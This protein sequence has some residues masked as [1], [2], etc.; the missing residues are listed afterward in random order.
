MTR[1]SHVIDR[2]EVVFD[3][4]RLV[5]NAGLLLVATLT[6]QLGL[7]ALINATVKLTGRVGGSRPGRKVLTLVNSMIAGGTH[8]DHADVLRS[9]ST[10]AVLSHRVMA[11]STLGTFLRAFTFGHVRQLEAVV[12]QALTR[13]WAAGAGPKVA[14][15]VID[16]D[17]TICEVDGKAKQ[18]AGYGYTKKLGYHPLL[19]TR[20]DTGEVLHARMRKGQANTQRGARRFIDEVVAR[21]RRAGATGQL[22][23]RVDSGFWS[24]ETIATLNRLNVRYTMS[25]K[26]K[27]KGIAAAIATIADT[28]WTDIDYTPDGQ[29]QVAECAYTSG[30]GRNAVTRRLIVRR[31]RLTDTAQLKLWPDWRHHGLLTDID[32]DVVEVDKFHRQHAVVELA[33][34]DLKQGSGLEHIPSGNFHA[35]SAWLQCAVLAHNMIR[36]TAILGKTRVDNQLIV[37]RTLRTQMIAIPGRIVNRS[38]RTTLRMPTHW[39]W[40][41]AFTTA[42]D[43]LRQLRP[44]PA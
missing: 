44:A 27:T 31:T 3:E 32:G 7:E 6:R 39:P 16:I 4:P 13:A 28:A 40:A 21:V 38:G 17:S 26:T 23:V 12:G 9:G 8:I 24:N 33:I 22:T 25:V 20:A 11:P 42:L 41:T 18:G 30:K 2:V 36:W 43:A 19:A 14:P 34:R 35:N 10:G 29:A 1:V 37:A 5:A 15:L